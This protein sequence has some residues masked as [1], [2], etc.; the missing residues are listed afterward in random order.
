[1]NAYKDTQTWEMALIRCALLNHFQD[2]R[3][4]VSQLMRLGLQMD[5]GRFALHRT[6]IQV[7]NGATPPGYFLS[8][9]SYKM[10]TLNLL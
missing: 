8:N 4:R 9:Y 6:P 2:L 5:D 3:I 1:M 10:L 7:P